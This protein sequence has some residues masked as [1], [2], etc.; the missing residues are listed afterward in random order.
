[1]DWE[2]VNGVTGVVSALSGI[3]G[4]SF[5]NT[6]RAAASNRNNSVFSRFKITSFLIATSGWALLCLCFLWFFEPFGSTMLD[7]EYRKFYAIVIS[8]P[9]TI[10]FIFGARLLLKNDSWA[11]SDNNNLEE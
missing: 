9:A 4:I 6:K 7:R 5:L 2:I 10:F 8:G 11:N 1:M 3:F